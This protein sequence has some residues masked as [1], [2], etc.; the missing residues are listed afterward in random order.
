M[1]LRGEKLQIIRLDGENELISG[2]SFKNFFLK[3]TTKKKLISIL[4]SRQ[5]T[6]EF[7]RNS[8]KR[9]MKQSIRAAAKTQQKHLSN[10]PLFS[11]KNPS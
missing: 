3:Y 8:S 5:S 10:R 6:L 4:Y 1:C 11:V 9:Q 7:G 2:S